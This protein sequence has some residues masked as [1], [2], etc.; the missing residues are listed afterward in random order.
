[1]NDFSDVDRSGRAAELVEHLDHVDRALRAPGGP[2]ERLRAHLALA[3]GSRVLDLGCGAGHELVQLER[4]GLCAFGVDASATMLA[5]SRARLAGLG[6][7]ARLVRADA[8]HLPFADRQ[9]DGCRIERVLQH[10]ASPAAVL[11]GAHRVL[12]PGGLIAVLEPDWASL[13]LVSQDA[14][15][16]RAVA[17]EAGGHIPHRDIG[18]HL[19]RLLA[20]AGF[21]DVRV[22]VELMVYGSVE[23]LSRMVSLEHVVDRACAAGRI[24]HSRG[25]A[26]LREQRSLSKS[27][28]FHATIH[29]SVLAWA[30]RP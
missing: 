23:D 21:V 20:D 13:T 22:D 25:V 14:E 17:D 30:R 28:A 27:G 10:V 19:R 9:F 4:D 7:P 15:A 16:A 5:A 12:R 24:E 3:P 29:R 6:H 11:A 18:R 1:M 8:Q 26:L 2:K